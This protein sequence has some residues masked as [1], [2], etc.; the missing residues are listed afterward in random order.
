MHDNTLAAAQHTLKRLDGEEKGRKE[1]KKPS[2]FFF[3]SKIVQ[4]RLG[5]IYGEEIR[6]SSS[7]QRPQGDP[8]HRD[9][10]ISSADNAFSNAFEPPPQGKLTAE[11]KKLDLCDGLLAFLSFL[12]NLRFAGIPVN[13]KVEYM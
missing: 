6:F 7:S 8:L 10:L 1:E 11:K 3:F 9:E 2:A 5:Y 4:I 12:F 13:W